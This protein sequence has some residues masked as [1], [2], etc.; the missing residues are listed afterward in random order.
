MI[1]K[2]NESLPIK[3]NNAVRKKNKPAP[4]FDLVIKNGEYVIVSKN[5]WKKDGKFETSGTMA[6]LLA[7]CREKEV[8]PRIAQF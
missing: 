5:R 3:G 1:S 8:K 6:E 2:G 4:L 7:F